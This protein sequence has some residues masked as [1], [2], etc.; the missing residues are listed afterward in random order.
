MERAADGTLTQL[1][2]DTGG[3]LDDISFRMTVAVAAEIS[4]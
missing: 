2:A 1:R 3:R 4:A